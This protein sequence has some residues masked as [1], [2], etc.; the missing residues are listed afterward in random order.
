MQTV[1]PHLTSRRS[2]L[3]YFSHLLLGL[4]SGL[5]HSDLPTKILYLPLFTSYLLHVFPHL[6]LLGLI[7][8]IMCVEYR[9]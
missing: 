7:T 5:L 2:I 9:S 8:G 4:L 3:I 1:P 6:I